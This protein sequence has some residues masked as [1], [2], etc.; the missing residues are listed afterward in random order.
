[1][2]RQLTALKVVAMCLG[3]ARQD[4]LCYIYEEY[5]VIILTKLWDMLLACVLLPCIKYSLFHSYILIIF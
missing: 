4:A 5:E 1:M 3:K 2:S